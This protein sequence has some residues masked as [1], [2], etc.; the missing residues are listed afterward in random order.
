[1]L[2]NARRCGACGNW[3]HRWRQAP[4]RRLAS[5]FVG[6]QIWLDDAGGWCEDKRF[7][8][9]IT[10]GCHYLDIMPGYLAW[11]HG[12]CVSAGLVYRPVH[13]DRTS[14]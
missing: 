9:G 8:C 7:E 2:D 10:N 6:L 5:P 12:P 13:T 11:L 1:M 4:G 3:R 14:D